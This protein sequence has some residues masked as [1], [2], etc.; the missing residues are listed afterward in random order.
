MAYR[1]AKSRAYGA[2]KQDVH[3]LT[4]H[5]VGSTTSSDLATNRALLLAQLDLAEQQYMKENWLP[6]ES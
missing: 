3:D 1:V 5:W 6:K 4:W 2:A